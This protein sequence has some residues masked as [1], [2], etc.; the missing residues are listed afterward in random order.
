[1][2]P[3]R[4][5]PP[6]EDPRSAQTRYIANGSPVGRPIEWCEKNTVNTQF[7]GHLPPL[8]SLFHPFPA[9]QIQLGVWGIALSFPIWVRDTAPAANAFL[10]L[11]N[12]SGDNN[13][14]YYLCTAGNSFF[15]TGHRRTAHDTTGVLRLSSAVLR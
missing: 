14:G 9:S 6:T 15:A 8:P 7:Q 3:D 1:M 5:W 2:Q 10:N 13:F 4:F 12:A 11:E